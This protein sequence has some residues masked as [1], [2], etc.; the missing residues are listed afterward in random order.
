MPPYFFIGLKMNRR[1]LLILLVLSPF[2]VF[3][4]KSVAHTPYRQW[5]VMRQR[6]LLIHS[7]KTDLKTDALAD[8]IVDSLA[9]MLP[10]AK[11]RVARARNAQRVGSLI[12]TGQ[13]MLAVMSVKDAIN[14]YR[15]TSQFKGLNTGMIRTLLRNKEFVLV[16]SAEFPMEHAWLV[17]SALM[18]ESNAVLDIPDNSADAPIPM[19][20]GARAY[21]KG[22][23][24]ESVKKNG[25]M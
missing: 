12:T 13:A 15:G 11:A 9:I 17:T 25:E 7:Y 18:H 10:D 6:F 3:G 4:Q 22:E 1:K 19:H 5:K 2:F 14:L 8:R 24:F 21:A 20:S 23:T 16:A